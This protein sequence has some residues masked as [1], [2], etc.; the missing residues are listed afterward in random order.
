ME[1]SHAQHYGKRIK[2]TAHTFH[3]F[4]FKPNIS[5]ASRNQR[6]KPDLDLTDLFGGIN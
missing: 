2:I 5:A 6:M 1:A 3:L 4:R